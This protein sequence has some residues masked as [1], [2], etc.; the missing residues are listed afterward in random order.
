MLATAEGRGFGLQKTEGP[1]GPKDCDRALTL[2]SLT[3]LRCTATATTAFGR[4]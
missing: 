1:L 3:G 4:G 2:S